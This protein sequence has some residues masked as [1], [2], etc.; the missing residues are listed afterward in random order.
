MNDCDP[1]AAV[2]ASRKVWERK[3][4]LIK[5]A[6]A[7]KQTRRGTVRQIDLDSRTARLVDRAGNTS[8]VTFFPSVQEDFI[9][10]LMTAGEIEYEWERS[11]DTGQTIL[12]F[13]RT[14]GGG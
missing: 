12:A 5:E 9:R 11:A 3:R 1:K 8:H 2:E 4:R 6:M 14:P 10:S 7:V 13:V